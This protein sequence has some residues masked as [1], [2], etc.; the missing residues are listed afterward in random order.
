LSFTFVFC[1]LNIHASAN[2]KYFD[3]FSNGDDL[4]SFI[5]NSLLIVLL[6]SVFVFILVYIFDDFIVEMLGISSDFVFLGV[7]VSSI[8]VCIQLRLGQWQVSGKPVYFGVFLIAQSIVNLGLSLFF[9]ISL[10]WG[11][12][13]RIVGISIAVTSFSLI[14][15]LLLCKDKLITISYN[16]TQIREALSFGAPLIPHMLGVFLLLTI[17]RA[18]INAKLGPDV[19]GL[20]MVAFQISLAASILLDSVNKA[21]SPWLYSLLSKPTY[22]SKI[23]IVKVTYFLYL[24]IFV[25]VLVSWVISKPIIELLVGEEFWE[26]SELVPVL[27]GAQG[28]RGAYLFVTNYLFYS[29]KTTTLAF[30]T[31]FTGCINLVLLMI[32]IDKFGAIGAAYSLLISMTL[33]WIITWY[34]ANNA[35]RLPWFFQSRVKFKS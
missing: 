1:S 16:K 10:N 3:S 24:L 14:A 5:F 23:L 22:E 6:S 20:Y 8:S 26:A 11:L 25:G 19:T 31:I 13:G 30:I 4:S 12:E 35:V 18:L 15:F 27:I 29:K 9:V 7:L 34:L 21:F 28:I 32:M 33:Q 2:R 17:D